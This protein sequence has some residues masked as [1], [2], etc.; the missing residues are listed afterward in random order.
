MVSFTSVV[1]VVPFLLAV[2]FA[3][4]TPT[5][6]ANIAGSL[7]ARQGGFLSLNLTQV[8]SQCSSQCGV[9]SRLKDC[10]V[11][12]SCICTDQNSD[13]IAACLKCFV[14]NDGK[15]LPMASGQKNMDTFTTE[16]AAAGVTVKVQKLDKPANAAFAT[17]PA[18]LGVLGVALA[19][20]ATML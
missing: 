12:P 10:G 3:Q 6:N 7:V 4:A 2:P 13:D 9:T 15:T 8:P 16:C 11:D 18:V 19:T 5:P 17:R 1:H 20:V 14:D